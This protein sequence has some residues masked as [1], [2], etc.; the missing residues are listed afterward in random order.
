[1]LGSR[2]GGTPWPG[3]DAAP[4]PRLLVALLIWAALIGVAAALGLLGR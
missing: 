2:R 4:P 3:A 1:M